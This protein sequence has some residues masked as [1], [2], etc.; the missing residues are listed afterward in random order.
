MK[1]TLE[2][3]K[4]ELLRELEKELEYHQGGGTRYRQ[5]TTRMAME[6]ARNQA[7]KPAQLVRG[8]SADLVVRSS[9]RFENEDRKRDVSKMLSVV[10]RDLLNKKT[11]PD[12]VVQFANEK[13]KNF[14]TLKFM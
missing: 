2:V 8:K 4:N 9:L 13:M 14:K 1:S 11:L 5:E 3:S 6:V 12:D 10:T 7:V